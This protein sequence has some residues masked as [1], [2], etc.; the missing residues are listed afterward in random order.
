V[1]I[2]HSLPAAATLTGNFAEIQEFHFFPKSETPG[3][4]GLDAAGH[5]VL[6][7]THIVGQSPLRVKG[8]KH[9]RVEMFQ[10]FLPDYVLMAPV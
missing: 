3:V 7:A 9:A 8:K 2:M 6:G 5:L 4:C 1:R 10:T